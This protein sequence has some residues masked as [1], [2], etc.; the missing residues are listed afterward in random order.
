MSGE[1]AKCDGT[2]HLLVE[3][4]KGRFVRECSCVADA[5]IRR[6]LDRAHVPQRYQRCTLDDYLTDFPGSNQ[7]LVMA[8]L[9]ATRFVQRFPVETGATGVMLVGSIGVGKTH[10]AVGMLKAL[11]LER[12]AS[13]LFCDYR[14]LLKKLQNTYSQRG[15]GFEADILAPILNAEVLVLDELGAAKPTEWV[16][17]TIGYVLNTRYNDCRTTILTTNYANQPAAGY[18]TGPSA[19]NPLRAAVR[20]DTLGDRI[21]E[22]IRSRLQEMCV[23]LELHGSDFRQ[24]ARPAEFA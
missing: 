3:G 18:E 4:E 10:L 20:Q 1:C 6:E 13:G 12:G 17:D 7:S 14:E 24:N 9:Y 22:R 8:H 19:V 23:P 16:T 11:I 5:K 2:G 15:D 21:G